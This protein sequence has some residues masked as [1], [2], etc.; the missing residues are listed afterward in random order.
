MF[1]ENRKMID[2]TNHPV[3]LIIGRVYINVTFS[4]L[5]TILIG[6]CVCLLFIIVINYIGKKKKN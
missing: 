1:R 5:L 6:S 3:Y 4:K 2:R